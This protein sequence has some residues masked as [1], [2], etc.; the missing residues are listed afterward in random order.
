MTVHL[1]GSA[2][3]FDEDI[4]FYRTIMRTIYNHEHLLAFDWVEPAFVRMKRDPTDETTDW[5]SILEGNI[6]AIARADL[7][8]IEATH[9][10]FGQGYHAALALQQKKPVLLLSRRKNI[11]NRLASGIRDEL[12]LIKTYTT[13]AE[14]EKVVSKFLQ[15]NVLTNKDFRFNFFLDREIYN[16]LRWASF[17]TGK[18]KA[19]IIRQLIEREITDREEY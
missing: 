4:P 16:H 7:I 3:H 18:T 17:K 2:H 15:D 12:L 13:E 5:S 19:E 1:T 6:E 10:G 14:L 11:E 8:I 9:Y